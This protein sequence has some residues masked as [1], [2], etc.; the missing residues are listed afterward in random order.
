MESSFQLRWKAKVGQLAYRSNLLAVNGKLYVP[1]NGKQFKDWDLADELNGVHILDSKTGKVIKTL[2]TGN[3]GDADVC[4]I[5]RLD[6]RLFFGNDNEEFFCVDLNGKQIWK[7]LASGDV[8]A[9]PIIEDVNKDGKPDLVFATDAGEIRAVEAENGKTIWS[10]KHKDFNGWSE[11]D[12]RFVFKIKR[13]FQLGDKFISSL[14]ATDLT[15]DGI[16]DILVKNW[17]DA[18]L[19]AVNGKTG[20][21]LW[22]RTC[23]SDF[24]PE[25][26]SF[27]GK[28][29]FGLVSSYDSIVVLNANGNLLKGFRA[30]EGN[31][32]NQGLTLNKSVKLSDGTCVYTGSD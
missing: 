2:E 27:Q 32:P 9:A 6:N 22:E 26:I 19:V 20:T 29:A 10:F 25:P 4:G 14:E 28:L 30:I 23:I 21:K 8:E 13:N 16:K 12:S 3:W 7:I 31:S 5:T 11:T 18:K 17:Y 1:S 24:P 15:G